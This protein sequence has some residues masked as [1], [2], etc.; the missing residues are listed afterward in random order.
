MSSTGDREVS[1]KVNVSQK[2]VS[3]GLDALKRDLAE[4]ERTPLHLRVQGDFAK[5]EE[6][7]ARR[8]RRLEIQ[9]QVRS[10]AG[11]EA[12]AEQYRSQRRE[13]PFMTPAYVQA[14]QREHALQ[15][16]HNRARMAPPNLALLNAA[17]AELAKQRMLVIPGG[18]DH[19]RI[20]GEQREVN[21]ERA[22]REH[23]DRTEEMSIARNPASIQAALATAAAVRSFAPAGSDEHLRAVQEEDALR[24]SLAQ[25]AHKESMENLGASRSGGNVQA[26]LATAA[27]VRAGAPAGSDEHLRAAREMRD[28]LKEQGKLRHRDRAVGMEVEFGKPLAMLKMMDEKV[29]ALSSHSLIAGGGLTGM[30]ASF[31]TVNNPALAQTMGGSI[32]LL[33]GE[34]GSMFIPAMARVIDYTQRAQ[35]A[36]HNLSPETKETISNMATMAATVSLGGYGLSRASAAAVSFFSSLKAHEGLT[37]AAAAAN[38]FGAGTGALAIAGYATMAAGGGGELSHMGESVGHGATAAWVLSGLGAAGRFAG[39]AGIAFGAGHYLLSDILRD[40]SL[41]PMAPSSMPTT[42]AAREAGA[43]AGQRLRELEGWRL[44]PGRLP[45]MREAAI[46]AIA[47]E[48]GLTFEEVGVSREAISNGPATSL[49]PYTLGAERL[50]EIEAR[51]A[52]SITERSGAPEVAERRRREMRAGGRGREADVEEHDELRSRIAMSIP[53]QS[54]QMDIGSLHRTIQG[55]SMRGDLDQQNFEQQQRN[56]LAL[57]AAFEK[58]TAKMGGAEGGDWEGGGAT[59]GDW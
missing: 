3:S 11:Y 48:H 23:R 59:A 10:K 17:A 25:Q 45:G 50:A 58:L 26:A 15:E 46:A 14:M 44:G 22:G 13:V 35:R 41:A 56:T 6:N 21:R 30:M 55:E 34:I 5:F 18:E 7:L 24:R 37:E 40:R 52:R 39:P 42:S 9:G 38:R 8:S 31:A 20:I 2:V 54:Q 53:F 28:L 36:L 47:R 32:Q 16:E 4:F 51:V 43:R 57:I 27:A 29:Q 49:S 33:T 12:I 19:R 1:V